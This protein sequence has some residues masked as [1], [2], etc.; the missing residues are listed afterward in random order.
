MTSQKI[1]IASTCALLLAGAGCGKP[2]PIADDVTRQTSAL[3]TTNDLTVS[4]IQRLPTLSWVWDSPNPKVEGWPTAGQSVTWRGFIKN[5]SSVSRNVAYKWFFDGT[6]VASS[7]VSVAANG[8]GAVDLARTWDFNRHTIKLVVDP[9]NV[10]AEDEEQNND[11]TVYSNAISAGFWVE[12]SVYDY[13]KAHQRELTGAKSTCWENWIQRQMAR[14]NQEF[15]DA[16]YGT[17]TP[18]GV[19]D[20]VRVD[21]IVIVQ[22]GALPL[23]GGAATNDPDFS[24]RT[25]D[26]MWG[27]PAGLLIPDA[28]GNLLYGNTTDA[29]DG[30]AFYFEGSLLHEL[31]HARYLIDNYGFNVHAVPNG[32]GRDKIAIVDGGRNIVGTPLLP[33]VRCDMAYKNR[34]LGL[35]D[36]D[37]TTIGVYSAMALNLIAG[38]RAVEGNYNAPN[39]IGIFMRDLPTQ[40]RITLLDDANGAALAGA[41]VQV[42]RSAGTGDLYGKSYPSTPWRTFTA[43]SSGQITLPQNPFGDLPPDWMHAGSVALLRV[44]HNGRVRYMFIEAADFNLEFWRGHTSLGTYTMRVPFVASNRPSPALTFDCASYW[45]TSA[46][47]IGGDGAL[48]VSNISYA[49]ITSSPITNQ[50]FQLG[51]RVSYDVAIPSLQPNP[52]WIGVA[53]LFIDVPSRNVNNAIIGSTQLTGMPF[54][55]FNTITY[56]MPQ[57]IRTALQG[58]TYS[59]MRMKVVLNV[60]QGSGTYQ[61]DNIKFLP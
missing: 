6:Q 10:I 38:R 26:L 19:L 32:T 43:N 53:Q 21:E 12:Q 47:N 4:H 37:R 30:N 23:N 13:F 42:Y 24:D 1:A 11:L 8:T 60:N 16:R 27:F 39:N 20:R 15:Q 58:A 31:G 48:S 59:D 33:L 50:E 55:T 57:W 3:A 9:A 28:Q 7:S 18:N 49:E 46:G 22:D 54:D 14:Y 5:F 52:A 2:D 61:L 56:T 25:V 51:T 41:S 36:E 29:N 44:A 40:N 17:D 34:Q 35:M 45:T